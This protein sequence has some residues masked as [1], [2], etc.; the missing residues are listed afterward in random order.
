M[1]I[2]S[3]EEIKKNNYLNEIKKL[4]S[5]LSSLNL[6]SSNLIGVSAC[7]LGINCRYNGK[8]SLRPHVLKFLEKEKLIPIPLC[9]ESMGGLPIPRPPAK[10]KGKDGFEVLDGKA[11]VIQLSTNKDVT[12]NFLKGT[13]DCFKIVKLLNLKVCLLKEKSP[14]CGVNYIYK[15]E[16]DELKEGKGVF[17]AFLSRNNIKVFSENDI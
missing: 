4:L 17:A 5:N 8:A 1:E 14:S 3:I 2:K 7:L 16:V 15:F 13:Y 12:L 11:K 10:I 6:E 9:P